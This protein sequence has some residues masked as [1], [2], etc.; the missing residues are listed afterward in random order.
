M[1]AAAVPEDVPCPGHDGIAPNR[2]LSGRWA[3]TTSRT[4]WGRLVPACWAVSGWPARGAGR[5]GRRG[6]RPCSRGYGFDRRRSPRSGLGSCR[7]LRLC[8]P[9]SGSHQRRPSQEQRSQSLPSPVV[10]S[11]PV[12]LPDTSTNLRGDV[13]LAAAVGVLGRSPRSVSEVKPECRLDCSDR[14]LNRSQDPSGGLARRLLA[15]R[16]AT[17]PSCP[18][19]CGHWRRCAET[20]DESLKPQAPPLAPLRG[21]PCTV[22]SAS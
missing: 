3:P 17:A 9:A 5:R 16:Q 13:G 22:R 21:R 15:G 8:Q 20:Y 12:K 4:G 2:T 14:F 6:S 18:S 10:S 19:C 1:V 11:V 7:W